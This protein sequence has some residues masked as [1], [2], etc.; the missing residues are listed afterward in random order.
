MKTLR[1]KIYAVAGY[2]TTY[3]GSGRKEFNPKKWLVIVLSV[4]SWTWETIEFGTS[5]IEN[6]KDF[7]ILLNLIKQLYHV[8]AI[9][10]QR[11]Q[12]WTHRTLK[13][14]KFRSGRDYREN[15]RNG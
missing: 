3:F 12:R 2:N 15:H 13:D 9:R 5:G 8:V 6:I 11:K 7:F 1:K 4:A 10:Y 14:Q